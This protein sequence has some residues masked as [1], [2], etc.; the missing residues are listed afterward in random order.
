MVPMQSFNWRRLALGAGSA[1]AATLAASLSAG[2]GVDL[3]GLGHVNAQLGLG[4]LSAYLAGWATR[5]P[6]HGPNDAG[7]DGK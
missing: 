5:T 6:G 1:I 3:P 4:A 2:A 7:G